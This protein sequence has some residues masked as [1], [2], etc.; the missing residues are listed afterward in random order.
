[1]QFFSNIHILAVIFIRKYLLQ[2]IDQFH[3]IHGC[4]HE[5]C[6]SLSQSKERCWPMTGELNVI[7]RYLQFPVHSCNCRSAHLADLPPDSWR[8]THFLSQ[9]GLTRLFA[10]N[11]E[12]SRS[13]F[14]K[15]TTK[16]NEN[17]TV[18][19]EPQVDPS[20]EAYWGKRAVTLS[21]HSHVPQYFPLKFHRSKH[22]HN[23]SIL[24]MFVAG[25][26]DACRNQCADAA[27]RKAAFGR[28]QRQRTWY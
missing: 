6:F 12:Q 4:L 24:L 1:M 28:T 5:A 15:N 25:R 27:R 14:K 8:L 3:R 22:W 10:A 23:L 13:I 20:A 7:L 18:T 16:S 2:H 9:S 26:S 19:S 11:S 17:W 21:L